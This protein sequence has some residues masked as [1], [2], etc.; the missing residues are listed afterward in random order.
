MSFYDLCI[1]ILAIVGGSVATIG[2]LNA[3]SHF[4]FGIKW[5]HVYDLNNDPIVYHQYSILP[6]LHLLMWT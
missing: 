5:L 3:I 4:I 2:V 6:L 1:D